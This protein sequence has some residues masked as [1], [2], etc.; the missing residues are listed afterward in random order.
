MSENKIREPGD[1]LAASEEML[2]GPG[3]YDDGT[4]VRAAAYGEEVVDT[5]NFA[6]GIKPIVRGV[7]TIEAGDIVLGEISVVRPQMAGVT[8]IDVRGKSGRSILQ[9]VEGTLHVSGIDR[10]YIKDVGD[11][12]R[13]GDVIRAKVI[14]IRGGP[15]L[16][17]DRPEYGIL[18]ATCPNDGLVLEKVSASKLKCTEC[19]KVVIGK[20]ASDYGS[21]RV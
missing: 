4:D 5:Q 2:P 21:G 19:D 18:R 7:T 13:A 17:T 20:V 11:E 6:V 8:I 9:A 1:V 10:R 12:Y 14:K 3:A 15:Q 16:V